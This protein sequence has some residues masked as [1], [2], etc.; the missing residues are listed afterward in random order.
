M[1]L[2]V[3]ELSIGHRGEEGWSSEPV[4]NCFFIIDGEALRYVPLTELRIVS[5]EQWSVEQARLASDKGETL[6]T[7]SE[8]NGDSDSSVGWATIG[9]CPA[10]PELDISESLECTVSLPQANFQQLLDGCLS[11]RISGVHLDGIGGA[12]SSSFQYG[13]ARDLLLCAGN[14][15]KIDIGSID[16]EYKT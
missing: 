10:M 2:L 16:L 1:Q 7:K 14:E 13:A 6:V 12:L 15:F 4:D 8:G 5:E 3:A 9:H 11:G